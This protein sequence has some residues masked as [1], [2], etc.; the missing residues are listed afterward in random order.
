MPGNLSRI[1]ALV[2]DLGESL[3]RSVAVDNASLELL[4]ASAQRGSID[5]QRIAAIINRAPP[6]EPV[7][8]MLS[9]GIQTAHGPVRLP[10]NED[11]GMLPRV[12]F[13][14]R[15]EGTLCGYL[16]LFDVPPVSP[17]EMRAAAGVA[18]QLAPL[19]HAEDTELRRRAAEMA[20]LVAAAGD[21][22]TCGPA[23]AEATS[24]GYLPADGRLVAHS[25]ITAA[26]G[27]G[28]E[29]V[30]PDQGPQLELARPRAGRPY[31]TSYVPYRLTVV[32][33]DRSARDTSSTGSS[34][35]RTLRAAGHEVLSAGTAAA[36]SPAEVGTALRRASFAAEVSQL[37]RTG[38]APSD[39]A[40]LGAWRLLYGRPLTLE[41]VYE[42]S[43]D[44]RALIERGSAEQRQSIL[45]Y[46]DLGRRT[47]AVS[48]ALSVHRATLH[49]RL[50]R[51]R[52]L[53]G[54]DALDDGWRGTALHVSLKLYQA[55]A[56][57]PG[58]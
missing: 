56:R 25:V 16:W 50:E 23:I 14:I 12:C 29:S 7:P 4:C 6:M 30:L 17:D 44:A 36:G 52:E 32:S 42:V 5:Q 40:G 38:P 24:L 3:D 46:L 35:A 28:S 20:R 53:L 57:R 45:A 33:R 10:A 9:Q 49:Y 22:A 41:T 19:M 18:A 27:G 15:Q 1:Q 2:D 48:E 11:F 47:G 13:P 37:L 54:H 26:G 39:W 21:E 34:I 8:W 55:L 58:E 31:L 51:I 43:D